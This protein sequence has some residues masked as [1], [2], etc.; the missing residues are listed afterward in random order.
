[1]NMKENLAIKI[2]N[3]SKRYKIR[4]DNTGQYSTLR[5]QI[6][7]LFKRTNKSREKDFW[8]LNNI[9]LDINKG[10]RVALIGHNGAG[11]STLLKILSSIT[12]PTS[13]HIEIHG[14]VTSLLEVGTGFHPEL[15]G[16]ENIFLNGSIMGMSRRDIQYK[17]NDIVDFA[18][19][20]EFID[21]PLK[22]YSSGM[23][24]RL[25]FAVAAHLHSDIMIVDEVLAVGDISFQQKCIGK[26]DE[27]SKG[28]GRT[29]LFVSHNLHAVKQLCNKGVVLDKGE[30]K[31]SG[32]IE[33]ASNYYI[34]NSLNKSNL[35]YKSN[36]GDVELLNVDAPE[37]VDSGSDWTVRFKFNA[38]ANLDGVIFDFGLY[39]REYSPIS[40]VQGMYNHEPFNIKKGDFYITATSKHVNLNTGQYMIGIYLVTL[41][42]KILLDVLDI[43]AGTIVNVPHYT[44]KAAFISNEATITMEQ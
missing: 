8:A 43:S 7:N 37:K 32:D 41:K 36:S 34:N 6:Y 40:H 13:G 23:Q 2:E 10:D 3:V 9:N 21:T 29:I 31:F 27:I 25:G 4:E 30:I 1:M 17:F 16:R 33:D 12:E 24:A 44:G 22:R 15:T 38:K 26:M 28:E 42:G 20:V 39:N 5:E 11:K 19:I 18:G 14:S 35:I